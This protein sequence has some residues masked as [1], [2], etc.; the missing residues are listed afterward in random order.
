MTYEGSVYSF[1]R[2]LCVSTRVAS[3]VDLQFSSFTTRTQRGNIHP[4]ADAA[5]APLKQAVLTPVLNSPHF[6]DIFWSRVSA[7]ALTDA[8]TLL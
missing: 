6:H 5:T 2:E 3:P 4:S 7:P 8:L 1:A